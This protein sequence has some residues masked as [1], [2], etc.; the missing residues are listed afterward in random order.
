MRV[1]GPARGLRRPCRLEL[2]GPRVERVLPPARPTHYV[3]FPLTPKLPQAQLS[4]I[5]LKERRLTSLPRQFANP[6]MGFEQAMGLNDR[7][8]P[9]RKSRVIAAVWPA[10]ISSL[11][12]C[13]RAF[14]VFLLLCTYQLR[15]I[16][17]SVSSPYQRE[18]VYVIHDAAE[19]FVV[20]HYWTYVS[21]QP[22][23][24]GRVLAM[25]GQN[26]C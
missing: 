1:A 8:G 11:G 23:L 15:G 25:R 6:L 10:S 21:P 17:N 20:V 3:R 12:F 22:C 2:E 24:A 9:A 18:P 16:S 19:H 26:S 4:K 14:P 5:Q 13:P 7:W